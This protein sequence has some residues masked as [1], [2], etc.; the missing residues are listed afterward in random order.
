VRPTTAV[1]DSNNSSSAPPMRIHRVIGTSCTPDHTTQ[2]IHGLLGCHVRVGALRRGSACSVAVVQPVRFFGAPA[3][4]PR[5][6]SSRA[7]GALHRLAVITSKRKKR[8]GGE[9]EFVV[10]RLRLVR[11]ARL[12]EHAGVIGQVPYRHVR[13]KSFR[14]SDS[15]AQIVT[16]SPTGSSR[17]SRISSDRVQVNR[18]EL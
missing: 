1:C 2:R 7:A 17:L 13:S 9:R 6:H 8:G 4:A 14:R 5:R 12:G 16:P 11:W 10:L 3:H 18:A 15:S